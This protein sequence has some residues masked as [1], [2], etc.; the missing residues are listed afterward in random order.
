M[1]T[2]ESRPV[3]RQRISLTERRPGTRD[4][5]NV[6][7]LAGC[8]GWTVRLQKHAQDRPRRDSHGTTSLEGEFLEEKKKVF[9]DHPRLRSTAR[10]HREEIFIGVTS[11]EGE[12]LV[13]NKKVF[14]PTLAY[15]ARPGSTEKRFSRNDVLRR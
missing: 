5:V 11:L 15:G 6:S 10:I 9:A 12:I 3:T 1:C 4:P 2:Y 7:C 13:K 8:L 14:A